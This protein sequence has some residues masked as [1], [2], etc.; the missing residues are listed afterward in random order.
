VGAPTWGYELIHWWV[1]CA[2]HESPCCPGF[3][4]VVPKA[5]PLTRTYVDRL[6]YLPTKHTDQQPT[7]VSVSL[8]LGHHADCK[9]PYTCV[10]RGPLCSE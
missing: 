4:Q 8:L 9:L 7:R 6:L 2:D 10:H 1:V 5:L 3:I